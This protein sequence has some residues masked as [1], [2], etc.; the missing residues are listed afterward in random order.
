VSDKAWWYT[1]RAS[2]MVAWGLLAL[3]VCWG[4]A[5]ST[6]VTNGKPTPAWLL[7]LHRFLGGLATVFVG[8]HLLGLAEDRFVPFTWVDFAVP[9]H[10]AW[11]PIAVAWGVTALYLLVAIEITSL[12]MRKLP[13]RWWRKVHSSSFVLF[14]LTEIHVFAAG[15]DRVNRL[16]QWAGLAMATAVLF[17]TVYR[18]MAKPRGSTA[19]ARPSNR[20]V[21]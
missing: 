5:L 10:S 19:G 6:R 3:S 12:L 9:F 14:V 21:A 2:G 20:K 16:T 11:R 4:L 17:L 18:A 13:K 1:A 15:T 8:V 7:D